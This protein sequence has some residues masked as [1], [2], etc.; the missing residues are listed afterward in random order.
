MIQIGRP[1][2][3][4]L[5]GAL[6]RPALVVDPRDAF[7]RAWGE[8]VLGWC[9]RLGGPGVDPHD[10]A[11]DVFATLLRKF[12]DLDPGRDA[13][14]FVYAVTRGVVANHR[15]KQWWRRWLPSDREAVGTDDPAAEA[16]RRAAVARIDA[17]LGELSDEQREVV[18]LC[19][20]EER[21][22]EEVAG[23]VGAPAG[24]VKSRLRLARERLK[25][26]A[27]A[28]GLDWPEVAP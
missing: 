19:W 3:P 10:A 17:L 22:V 26:R 9:R 25:A 16:H 6:T 13:A 7:V 24:T 20:I 12:D 2:Q 11:Q 15:K 8:R 28:H 27:T 14:P 1:R 18:V 4:P 21:T 5:G 23:L